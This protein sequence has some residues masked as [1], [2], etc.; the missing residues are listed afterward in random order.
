M[1][2]SKRL[3]EKR[4]YF[5]P[6]PLTTVCF[7]SLPPTRAVR[8]I[9]QLYLP[10]RLPLFAHRGEGYDRE[11]GHATVARTFSLQVLRADQ[12][13]G[14]HLVDAVLLFFLFLHFVVPMGISRMGNS[15]RFP[16]GKPDATESRT[17]QL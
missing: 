3:G 11:V 9:K 8:S 16:Q 6:R 1:L 14:G 5:T 17:T 13:D 12:L 10:R 7:L 15:G 2:T 4:D